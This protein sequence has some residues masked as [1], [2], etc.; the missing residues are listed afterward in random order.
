M[1]FVVSFSLF[2]IAIVLNQSTVVGQTTAEAVLEFPKND[3]RGVKD[4]IIQ[5]EFL[6]NGGVFANKTNVQRDITTLSL[7]RK[8]S[9]VQFSSRPPIANDP[10]TYI[11]MHYNNGVTSYNETWKSK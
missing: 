9:V 5:S 10:Y 11:E 1:G 4:V 6:D 3:I 7:S 8:N 2:F